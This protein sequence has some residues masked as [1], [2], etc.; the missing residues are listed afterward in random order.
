MNRDTVFADQQK[1]KDFCFDKK[2]AD[3]FDNMVDR[4]VPFYQEI[5]RMVTEQVRDYALSGSIVCDLGCATGTT[6]ASLAE[7]LPADIKLT[8]I[9]N[10]PEMLDKCREK[11][12]H[13]GTEREI[14]LCCADLHPFPELSGISVAVSLLTLQFIRPLYRQELL[15]SLCQSMNKDGALI[16]VEKVVASVPEINRS[17]IQYY[18]EMKRRNGYSETEINQKREALEN[19]LIPYTT[20]E[21]IELL[22]K[23][24]FSHVEVFFK[25]YNFCGMVALK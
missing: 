15:T 5:Q 19:V 6:L 20:E 4:S 3:V 16:L 25:W 17:F 1:V 18:Y 10:S 14:Q 22:K 9:D 24:G 11:L 2:V 7:I 8:G 23:S 21:N 13:A 12:S